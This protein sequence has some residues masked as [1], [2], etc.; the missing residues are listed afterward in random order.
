MFDLLRTFFQDVVGIHSLNV[1]FPECVPDSSQNANAVGVWAPNQVDNNLMKGEL[2]LTQATC[3]YYV[4]SH[5][6]HSDI[7]AGALAP[8]I[9]Q[10]EMSLKNLGMAENFPGDP[11]TLNVRGVLKPDGVGVRVCKD[12]VD[13]V[14]S[15]TA[16]NPDDLLL[17]K[18]LPTENDLSA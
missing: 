15:F 3:V 17:P 9:A 7:P 12:I 2:K 10:A 18:I 6:L 14:V 4:Q 8:F 13:T 16:G 5:L 1:H 11:T